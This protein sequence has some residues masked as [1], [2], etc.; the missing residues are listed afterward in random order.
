MC[1]AWILKGLISLFSRTANRGHRP[2]EE[3]LRR[4]MEMAEIPVPLLSP[5]T[6][7]SE[8]SRA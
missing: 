3:N 1:E 2:R 6:G 8:R 7:P 5:R 4:L